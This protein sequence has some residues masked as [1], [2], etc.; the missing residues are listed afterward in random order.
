MYIEVVDAS[1][2]K[3]AGWGEPVLKY[4]IE[5]D[6]VEL[7]L[8]VKNET[9]NATVK[10]NKTQKKILDILHENKH[11]TY[12]EIANQLSIERTTVW[13]NINTMK[14]NKVIIR[15]GGDKNGSWEILL[16][17]VQ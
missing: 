1:A 7:V 5:L 2:W 4:K 15:V 11:A 16:V 14:K 3:E 8:P 10:L 13:R 17:N 12:D 6:E 9:V